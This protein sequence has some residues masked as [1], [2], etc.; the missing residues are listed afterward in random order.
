MDKTLQLQD[1][2]LFRGKDDV[3]IAAML[4]AQF[5]LPPALL[6]EIERNTPSV[7]ALTKYLVEIIGKACTTKEQKEEWNALM[8]DNDFILRKLQRAAPRSE[9]TYVS[10]AT[11]RGFSQFSV[12][13]QDEL[14]PFLAELKKIADR[15]KLDI[16]EAIEKT[17]KE[18]LI[19]KVTAPKS[20]KPKKPVI[21]DMEGLYEKAMERFCKGLKIPVPADISFIDF[22]DL[23]QSGSKLSNHEL[24]VLVTQFATHPENRVV[25]DGIFRAN[26]V[27]LRTGIVERG[28]KSKRDRLLDV[29]EACGASIREFGFHDKVR[30][31][32]FWQGCM[33]DLKID[34]DGDKDRTTEELVKK[35]SRLFTPEQLKTIRGALAQELSKNILFKDP[36]TADLA[37]KDLFD[38]PS[39]TKWTL[40]GQVATD[41]MRKLSRN[42]QMQPVMEQLAAEHEMRLKTHEANKD[43]AKLPKPIPADDIARTGS[44]VWRAKQVAVGKRKYTVID[45]GSGEGAAFAPYT[46]KSLLIENPE[47]R[48][49]LLRAM[50]A[51]AQ[52]CYEDAIQ[53]TPGHANADPKVLT[54]TLAETFQAQLNEFKRANNID[55]EIKIR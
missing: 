44:L 24:S 26:M 20:V 16:P 35:L 4:S 18:E 45:I 36:K 28:G 52:A 34:D 29:A 7:P 12:I 30:A 55:S 39:I 8:E 5:N 9:G 51:I 32:I 42:P 43:A 47:I 33:K 13:Y 23:M 31:K 17:R 22:F 50:P 21:D 37:A 15:M 53:K 2:L 25:G 10:D 6:Q 27:E 3:R 41:I 1:G 40:V 19:Q 14:E 48:D 46:S 11:T 49:K 38:N 54:F